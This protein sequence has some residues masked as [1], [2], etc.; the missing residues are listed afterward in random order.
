[1]ETILKTFSG[2]FPFGHIA[3][4]APGSVY[5]VGTRSPVTFD[6]AVIEAYLQGSSTGVLKSYGWAAGDDVLAMYWLDQTVVQKALEDVSPNTFDRPVLENFTW[7][8][9]G[10]SVF[11]LPTQ[12]PLIQRLIEG[13][14]LSMFN[15][16]PLRDSEFQPTAQL[17][18]KGRLATAEL[19]AAETILCA[20][21]EDWLDRATVH[22][23][24]AIDLLPQL[25]RQQ[26][27]VKDF[28]ALAVL[29]LIH[30]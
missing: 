14:E 23:K 29:S 22:F 18:G 19:I 27:V 1:M 25:N 11:G 3:V 2:E 10:H 12:L 26:H 6:P 21:E 24:K 13:D 8:S 30:I 9:Y 17:V 5:L 4:A 16:Q 7:A 20:G 28:R 15:G